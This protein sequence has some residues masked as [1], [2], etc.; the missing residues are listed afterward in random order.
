MYSSPHCGILKAY[1]IAISNAAIENEQVITSGFTNC[2]CI[3][4]IQVPQP[5]LRSFKSV[6]ESDNISDLTKH[7]AFCVNA[8]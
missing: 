7:S 8:M 3:S 2:S 5:T 1:K 4:D 6:G